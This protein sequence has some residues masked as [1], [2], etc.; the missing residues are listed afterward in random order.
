MKVNEIGSLVLLEGI[1]NHPKDFRIKCLRQFDQPNNSK[2]SNQLNWNP[3]NEN[4][5]E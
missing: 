3:K 4:S 5:S 1:E 2:S